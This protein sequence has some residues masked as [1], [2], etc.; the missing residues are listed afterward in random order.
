MDLAYYRQRERVERLNAVEAA[1]GPAR[2]AHLELADRYL[3]LVEAHER[4]AGLTSR[5]LDP[6]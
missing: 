5:T 3:A 1:D 4:L 2:A 6:V